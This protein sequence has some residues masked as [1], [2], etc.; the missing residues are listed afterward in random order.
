[1][2]FLCQHRNA[3]IQSVCIKDFARHPNKLGNPLSRRRI[4]KT[5]VFPLD[6]SVLIAEPKATTAFA[7]HQSTTPMMRVPN[8]HNGALANRLRHVIGGK[9]PLAQ[10]FSG[11]IP[12]SVEYRAKR[13]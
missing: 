3:C 4:A 6:D 1:M 7:V 13:E 2:Q 5:P 10:S 11:L 9:D 12:K 8:D